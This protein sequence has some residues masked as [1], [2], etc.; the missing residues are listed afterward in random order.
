MT[1]D[2]LLPDMPVDDYAAIRPLIQSG[3]VVA[4]AFSKSYWPPWPPSRIASVSEARGIAALQTPSCDCTHFGIVSLLPP[5]LNA[6]CV[7]GRLTW[8]AVNVGPYLLARRAEGATETLGRRWLIE[9]TTPC[10]KDGPLSAKLGLNTDS[11]LNDPYDGRVYI[12][13]WDD[14]DGAKA[15]ADAWDAVGLPYQYQAVIALALGLAIEQVDAAKCMSYICSGLVAE[16]LKAGGAR[17]RVPG[18]PQSIYE[19]VDLL[20]QA[21]GYPEPECYVRNAHVLWRLR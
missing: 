7:T 11:K 15:C 20:E 6:Y 9:A 19:P 13:R 3:D 10:V 18:D 14:V 16:A 2:V 1:Y 12:L 4:F 8:R 5:E 21:L 17:L